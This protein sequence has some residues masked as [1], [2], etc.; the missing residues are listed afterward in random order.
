ME[1]ATTRHTVIWFFSRAA[2]RRNSDSTAQ[3]PAFAK[4]GFQRLVRI[5]RPAQSNPGNGRRLTKD[6]VLISLL[7]NGG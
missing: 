4:T 3:H 5:R 1:R 7:S 2:S 6:D